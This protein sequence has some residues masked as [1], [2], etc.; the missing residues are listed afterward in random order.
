MDVRH[1]VVELV[2]DEFS[3]RSYDRERVAARDQL[4]VHVQ[5]EFLDAVLRPIPQQEVLALVL[6]V[7]LLAFSLLPELRQRNRSS[8]KKM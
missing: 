2:H 4:A 5:V 6:D 3:S 8:L 7:E 1:G